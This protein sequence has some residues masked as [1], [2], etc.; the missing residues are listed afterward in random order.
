MGVRFLYPAPQ[1]QTGRFPGSHSKCFQSRLDMRKLQVVI[2]SYAE[3]AVLFCSASSQRETLA[4]Q[5]NIYES[6][7]GRDSR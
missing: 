2:G 5:L 6:D 7:S 1:P 4:F 3:L